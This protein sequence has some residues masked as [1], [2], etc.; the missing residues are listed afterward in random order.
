MLNGAAKYYR[1]WI[2]AIATGII[3]VLAYAHQVYPRTEGEKLERRVEQMYSEG[4][5]DMREINSKFDKIYAV[6][7]ELKRQK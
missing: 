1:Q 2:L 3:A 5:E 6:L 7:L 4:K